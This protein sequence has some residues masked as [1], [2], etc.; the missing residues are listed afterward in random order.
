MDA[1]LALLGKHWYKP[2]GRRGEKKVQNSDLNFWRWPVNY[3]RARWRRVPVICHNLS[4][5]KTRAHRHQRAQ[6]NAGK[7]RELERFIIPESLGIAFCTNSRLV[8]RTPFSVTNDIPPRGESKL[9]V[10]KCTTGTEGALDEK[11]ASLFASSVIVAGFF[12]FEDGVLCLYSHFIK[13]I[14]FMTQLQPA[15]GCWIKKGPRQQWRE[16]LWLTHFSIVWPSHGRRWFRCIT[17]DTSEIYCWSF[18]NK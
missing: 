1:G 10:W 12:F 9:I 7:E 14:K 4:L 16:L 13:E 17:N 11:K 2:V 8:V 6:R 18:I 5:S 3:S 15:C